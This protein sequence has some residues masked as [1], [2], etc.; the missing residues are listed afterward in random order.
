MDFLKALFGEESLTFEQF[1][2][3]VSE[4]GLKVADLSTGN[5]VAKKKF[6]DE[7]ATKDATILDLTGQIKTRDTD[8]GKL[9]KQLEDDTV[10]K[11]TKVNELTT[12]LTNLQGEYKK[13]KTEYDT[14]LAQ[15]S[16]EFAVK[17]FVNTL[18][19]TS[20]AAKREFTREMISAKLQIKDGNIIGASDFAEDYKKENAASFVVEDNP[21]PESQ[22]GE[23][24][25]H[26]VQ[27]TPPAP[28]GEENP[29]SFNFAGVR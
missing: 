6:E 12:Q 3:K 25:P 1:T 22:P 17:D 7:L 4:A 26:F 14:K 29:F 5:Y 27:P 8:L 23:S 20:P 24:K 2:A 18:N 21:A 10:D 11:D 9:K 28:T 16:Y 15:Q 19:F 13:V